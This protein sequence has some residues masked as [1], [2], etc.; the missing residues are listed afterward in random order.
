MQPTLMEC[1]TN[2]IPPAP[3]EITPECKSSTK[4]PLISAYTFKTKFK[5][6]NKHNACRNLQYIIEIIANNLLMQKLTKEKR[7]YNGGS[8]LNK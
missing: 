6:R 3:S 7:I 2:M 8:C 5:S 4:Q 1:S